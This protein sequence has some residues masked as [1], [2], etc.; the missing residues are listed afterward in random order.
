VAGAV[1]LLVGALAGCGIRATTVPTDVGPAPSRASCAPFAAHAGVESA[2]QVPVQVY[3]VCTS[4]L[5]IVD[6]TVPRPAGKEEGVGFAQELL[7]QLQIR[8]SASEKQAGYTTKV[9]GGITVRGGRQG[10]PRNTLRLDTP[11][12]ELTTYALS[13]IVCTF[14]NSPAA[15]GDGSVIL[16]GPG[17]EPARRHHCTAEVRTHPGMTVPPTSP[18][19]RQD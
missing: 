12:W 18:V 15:A 6:R 14:A 13:Q 19:D 2:Q 8:P 11:P 10:E 5:V 7:D 9:L 17:T 3:L 1:V 16:G 4:Q